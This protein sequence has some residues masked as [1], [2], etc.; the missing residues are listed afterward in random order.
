MLE[1]SIE[2]Q[3]SLDKG[4]TVAMAADASRAF[5][6]RSFFARRPMIDQYLKKPAPSHAYERTVL[7]LECDATQVSAT[8]VSYREKYVFLFGERRGHHSSLAVCC[9]MIDLDVCSG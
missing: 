8:L 3:A 2:N 4:I 6:I 9:T 1:G 7:D 5:R